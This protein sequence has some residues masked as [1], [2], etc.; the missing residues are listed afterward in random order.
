MKPCFVS[1]MTSESLR[2]TGRLPADSQAC[3]A[4]LAFTCVFAFFSTGT[5]RAANHT[6]ARPAGSE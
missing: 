4:H 3:S 2:Q 6:F 1:K 5:C